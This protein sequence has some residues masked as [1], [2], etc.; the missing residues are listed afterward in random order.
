MSRPPRPTK[1][2]AQ[3]LAIA[4]VA[5]SALRP[6]PRNP[7][8]ISA[9]ARDR[10]RRGI[11]WTGMIDPI[12]ARREDGLVLG[13]HQRLLVAEQAHMATVPVIYLEG[14]S[15]AEADAI[16]VLLNNAEAQGEFDPDQLASLLRSLTTRGFDATL[17]GFD[18]QALEAML[19]AP[20]AAP[21][22]PGAETPPRK[23]KS[24]KGTIYELGPH[25]LLCGD[26][27]DGKA[28]A[29]LLKGE[30]IDLVYTDPPYGVDYQA[31]G[32]KPIRG[33]D[34]RRDALLRLLTAAFKPAKRA[35][36]PDAAWYVWHAS[37]T[38]R[39]FTDALEAVGLLELQYLTWVKPA[40]TLGWAHY[41]WAT[42]PCFYAGAPEAPPRWFGGRAESTVWR[43]ASQPGSQAVTTTLGPG[44]LVTDGRGASLYLQPQ[45][46]KGKK[47]RH[48]RL[49]DGQHVTVAADLGDQS[50]AWEVARDR[51]PDHPTQ[52]PVALAL[53][54][55][56][57]SSEPGDLVYDP[58]GGSGSTLLAAE[59]AG[60][61]AILV[62]LE[63]GYCDVIRRRYAETVGEPKLAP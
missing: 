58:F 53:R 30:R 5:P 39:E 21:E 45:A 62:E 49:A 36:R 8:R 16:N 27:C 54:A 3:P 57:N 11:E 13:G 1:A 10:L 7:R 32:Y 23:P 59:V 55:L 28:I 19:A 37:A 52:K 47:L 61:R 51:K 60:R 25:R 56:H 43:I 15:D 14:L 50:D 9:A 24:R 42:E 4:Y 33:D 41:Q 31:E 6:H 18:A 44:L 40:I 48:I 46:P 12:I 17:T 35:T 63:P 20:A 26:S 22:E 29:A 2:Q 34:Q 38:R